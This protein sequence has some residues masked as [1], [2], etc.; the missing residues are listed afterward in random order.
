MSLSSRAEPPRRIR[1]GEGRE[2]KEGKETAFHG[3]GDLRV[4]GRHATPRN[5]GKTA[6][7]ALYHTPHPPGPNV[8]IVLQIHP[9][10]SVRLRSG[11]FA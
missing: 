4:V 1:C 6:A 2:Q 5:P 11:D 8:T 7:I 10:T 9:P 3:S